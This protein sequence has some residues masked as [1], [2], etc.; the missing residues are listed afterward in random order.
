MKVKTKRPECIVVQA[1]DV[2]NNIPTYYVNRKGNVNG[3][4]EFLLKFP[5]VPSNLTINV[6]N[7]KNGNFPNMEDTSFTVEQFEAIPLATKPVWLSERDR[8]FLKFVQFF[9]ENASNLSASKIVNGK[10]LPSVYR[11]DCGEFTFDYYDKIR[12]KKTGKRLNTPARIGHESGTVEISKEDFLKYTVPMRMVILLHEY[13]HKWKNPEDGNQIGY[14]TG[15]DIN[16][17]LIYL[18]LGYSEI[19]AHQAFLYVFKGAASDGNHKRYL[20]IKDFIKKFSNGELKNY[21]KN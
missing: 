1:L 15:A 3:E 14:E 8:N 7:K 10:E 11:S 18:S 13:S 4:R 5:Q 9:C 20:I 2:V 12:D 19:E 16:A 17:L 6:F 21:T